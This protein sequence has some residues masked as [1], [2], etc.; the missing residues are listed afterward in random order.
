MIIT[1]IR[2]NIALASVVAALVGA[3]STGAVAYHQL[4]DLVASQPEI[5]KHLYDTSRH[6][7]PEEKRKMEGR[8]EELETRLRSLEEQRWRMYIDRQRNQNDY[9]RSTRGP[10]SR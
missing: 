2:E 7:D 8:I 5:Q 3:I 10:R 6:V 4:S 1:W 9:G